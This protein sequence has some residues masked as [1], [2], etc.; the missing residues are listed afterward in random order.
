MCLQEK[1][2]KQFFPG[3][4]YIHE[5]T[6]VSGY[7]HLRIEIKRF[8]GREGYAEYTFSIDDEASQYMLHIARK[9][10]NIDGENFF[11]I[12]CITTTYIILYI[13]YITAVDFL[14]YQF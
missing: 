4:R 5:L 10:G 2:I 13:Y 14:F 9:S 1:L 3:N 11:T 6:S 12:N 8:D 7:N